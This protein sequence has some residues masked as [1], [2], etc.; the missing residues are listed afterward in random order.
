MTPNARPSSDSR[1]A[2]VEGFRTGPG[3]AGR[4]GER[5]S[6]PVIIDPMPAIGVPDYD[7]APWVGK[8]GST[9]MCQ[10]A[11]RGTEVLV[12]DGDYVVAL[13][14]VIALEGAAVTFKYGLVPAVEI[15]Q[16]LDWGAMVLSGHDGE[17]GRLRPP[18]GRGLLVP[19]DV[20]R[21]AGRPAASDTGI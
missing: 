2:P 1:M 21:R 6:R 17:G 10:C 18:P 7:L 15:K 5:S 4:V 3:R 11:Q 16:L 20:M 14:R 13:S 8:Q 9:R 12:L 19:M